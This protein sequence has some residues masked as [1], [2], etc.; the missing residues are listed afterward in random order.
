[1]VT[2]L[3]KLTERAHQLVKEFA[4]TSDPD[5][6]FVLARICDEHVRRTSFHLE[7]FWRN[8]RA[9]RRPISRESAPGMCVLVPRTLVPSSTEP[10]L[11]AASAEPVAA[12]L[13]RFSI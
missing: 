3:E 8:P 12:P 7:P 13:G 4:H 5:S 11:D 1:M 9:R 2:L 6:D 10:K